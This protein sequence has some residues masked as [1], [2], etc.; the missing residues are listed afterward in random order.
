MI[1]KRVFCG[2]FAAVLCMAL[3]SGCGDTKEKEDVISTVETQG[4]ETLEY[5]DSTEA[6]EGTAEETVTEG[7]VS[8]PVTKIPQEIP[9][10][11]NG[12]LGVIAEEGKFIP[13][14]VMV[15][16]VSPQELLKGEWTTYF[17]YRT[18][19]WVFEWL[20]SDYA[21]EGNWFL[22]DGVLVISQEENAE[23]SQIIHVAAEGGDGVGVGIAH[24]FIYCDVSFDKIPD[25][26]ICT[27]HHGTQGFITYYCFLQTEDGF[28]ESPTFTEIANPA[29]DTENELI[30][31]QWRNMAVSHSWAEF[32]YQDGEYTMVRELCEDL[33]PSDEAQEVDKEIWVWTVNG[34]VLGRSDELT[35]EEIDNLIYN[36]NSEWGIMG[37][38]WRTLYNQGLTVDYSIYST[39]E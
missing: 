11:E 18:D 14:D 7:T 34:E 19:G 29:I 36:E 26:L 24:T 31:S 10:E 13:D 15:A 6:A 2:V 35:A 32:V 33:L 22:E 20:E 25:L 9:Q 17:R 37:D 4:T 1:Y 23:N 28:V 12:L 39:P 30:L 21:E 16:Q 8:K 27:G 3:L 38:R 5:M